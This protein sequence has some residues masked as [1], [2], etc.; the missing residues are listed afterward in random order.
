MFANQTYFLLTCL[1]D[2][3]IRITGL[4]LILQSA[5]QHFV[6][7]LF[8]MVSK[9]SLNGTYVLLFLDWTNLEEYFKDCLLYLS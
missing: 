6:K 9:S 1:E 3:N 2:A 7:F 8:V 4:Y 5:V